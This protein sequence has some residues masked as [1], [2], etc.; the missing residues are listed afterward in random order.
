MFAF[1]A[2][3]LSY[4]HIMMKRDMDVA[5]LVKSCKWHYKQSLDIM[6]S[7]N[8]QST[9]CEWISA[10]NG[11]IQLSIYKIDSVIFVGYC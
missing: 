6:R 5:I 1:H 7:I 2:T 4:N 8:A 3:I 10:A 9:Y 11:L